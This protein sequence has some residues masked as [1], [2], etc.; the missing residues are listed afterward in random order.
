VNAFDASGTFIGPLRDVE[1][2]PIEIDNLW[3]IEFGHDGGAANGGPEGTPHNSLFFTAG[4]NS[5]AN[6][7]FGVI[8]PPGN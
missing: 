3:G 2:K 4:P 5:Y 1:G 6:G 8:T 7:L